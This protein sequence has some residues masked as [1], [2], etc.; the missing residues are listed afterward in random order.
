[1][2]FH[3][4]NIFLFL[5]WAVL[6]NSYIC[7]SNLYQ[8]SQ[9]VFYLL[10]SFSSF[11][12]LSFSSFL[13]LFIPLSLHPSLFPCSPSVHPSSSLS[14]L[15]LSYISLHYLSSI[16]PLSLLY[17]SFISPLSLFSLSLSSI[18]LLYLPPLSLF[19]LSVLYVALSFVYKAST[20]ITI[21]LKRYSKKE[22]C[23]MTSSTM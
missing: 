10:L 23:G 6:L 18:S 1:M 2:D 22:V 16:S 12:P 8:C 7:A 17:I 15:S 20:N 13:P 4:C 9:Y 3:F 21:I 11:L 5:R 14:P 19:F